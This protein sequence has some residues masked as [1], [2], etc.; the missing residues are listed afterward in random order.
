LE[1]YKRLVLEEFSDFEEEDFN[2][3]KLRLRGVV[4]QQFIC[5]FNPISELHW[6]K[7]TIFDREQ[8]IEQPIYI[9]GITAYE[10]LSVHFIRFS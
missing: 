10:S 3:L 5:M 7:K 1:S 8:L 9:D 4:G 2:Q 6:I